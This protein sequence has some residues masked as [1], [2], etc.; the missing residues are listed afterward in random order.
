MPVNQILR[1]PDLEWQ[2][3]YNDFNL[4]LISHQ[5]TF[6]SISTELL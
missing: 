6:L 4:F 2:I 5:D 3:L 1:G